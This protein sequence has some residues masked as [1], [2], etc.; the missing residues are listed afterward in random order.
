MSPASKGQARESQQ[1]ALKQGVSLWGIVALGAGTAI[2]VAIFS[3]VAPGAA[4]AGP[5]MLLSMLIAVVP[6]ILFAVTYA[7][8]GSAAPTS[9]ASY[10]WSRRFIHPFVGFIIGWLRI[11]GSTSALVLYAFVLVQYWSMIVDLP[12]KPSMLAILAVFYLMNTIGVSVVARGQA[13]MVFV[14]LVTCTV[15]V[16]SAFAVGD[17]GNFTPMLTHGWNGVFA[18]VALMVSLFLGIEAATEVGEEVKDARRTIP[19]GIALS[20]VLTA[21]IYFAVAAA[22]IA[23]LG[24]GPLGAS[25]APLLD[26]AKATL[27]SYGQPLIL[28]SA[29]VA[30]GTSLNAISLIFSRSLFAMGRSGVLPAMLARVHPRWGTPWVATTV[31]FAL[32]TLGLLMP[33]NLVFL[34]LA[35]NI[36]TL[37]KYGATSFAA[38]R[39]V[40]HHRDIYDAAP[41]KLKPEAM[42]AWAWTG[43]FCALGVIALGLSAD[44]RPYA[45]LGGWFVL[46][47]V[48][49]AAR[50]RRQPPPALRDPSSTLSVTGHQR[51]DRT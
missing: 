21:S 45:V 48:Y 33:L 47:L 37:L 6:M 24:A 4:L 26:M 13:V 38:T 30:I 18:A 25:E 34:F 16:V 28:I 27:G 42:Q 44:W 2:G 5:A 43:V 12:P 49:Y 39:V 32:C 40:R 7:F 11:A 23:V 50:N 3:I 29:T 36:P 9:G 31:V 46:G 14:L 22:A 15:L 17:A 19:L 41:F 20:I 8:M 10:E 35:V 51:E 1:S